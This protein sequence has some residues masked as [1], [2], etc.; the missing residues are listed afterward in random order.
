MFYIEEAIDGSFFLLSG[1]EGDRYIA[2]SIDP[3]HPD[4]A[5]TSLIV[6]SKLSREVAEAAL[7]TA[8]EERK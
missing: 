2:D 6:A 5:C 4:A 1:R 3:A 8:L 7:K